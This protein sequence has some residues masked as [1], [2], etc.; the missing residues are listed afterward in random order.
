MTLAIHVQDVKWQKK[1]CLLTYLTNNRVI[2]VFNFPAES[3][4]GEE[5][6]LLS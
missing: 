2:T 6:K 4:I 5:L 3:K 1:I